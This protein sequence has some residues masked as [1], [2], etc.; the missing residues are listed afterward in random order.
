MTGRAAR[1]IQAP[2]DLPTMARAVRHI[3]AQAALAMRGQAVQRMMARAAPH[4]VV[5]VDLC[6][7]HRV[8]LLMTDLV[9]E[10]IAVRVEHATLAREAPVI[11]ARVG[12]V[13]VALQFAGNQPKLERFLPCEWA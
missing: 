6:R 13:G 10:L 1:V 5:R 7:D 9:D 2:V 11:Q 4:T 3:V 12:T 8:A